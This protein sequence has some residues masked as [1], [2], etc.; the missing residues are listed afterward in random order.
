MV[1]LKDIAKIAGVS[2]ST[3][4]KALNGSEE[5]RLETQEQIIQI[6]KDLKYEFKRKNQENVLK[7]KIIGVICP[8]LGSNYYTQLVNFIGDNISKKGYFLML[9]ITDFSAEK[10]ETILR[11]FSENGVGGIIYVTENDKTQKIINNSCSRNIP[12]VLIANDTD[13]QNH[14]Y[15]KIDDNYGVELAVEHLIRLGHKRIAYIGDRLTANRYKIYEATMERNNIDIDSKIVKTTDVRYEES[16]YRSM[17]EI[18]VLKNKPTALFAA[19]DD[20]AIGAVRAIGEAG[21]N[22][23]QDISV[24]GFDNIRVCPYLMVSLSTVSN[25]VNDMAEVSVNILIKKIESGDSRAIQHVVLR[26]E[27]IVRETTCSV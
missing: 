9:G 14:D 24:I 20:I 1:S 6:A 15:I 2:I 12:I 18:L 4:S 13:T 16:G 19:Y 22:I 10:E 21:L 27:L 11:L 23:P 3:V 25:P 7:S 8:E 26:P 5:I 17:Q